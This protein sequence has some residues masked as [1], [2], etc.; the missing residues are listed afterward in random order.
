[1]LLLL[2]SMTTSPRLRRCLLAKFAP[3]CLRGN[4][5]SGRHLPDD[6]TALNVSKS[7]TDETCLPCQKCVIHRAQSA[8]HVARFVC[9]ALMPTNNGQMPL[10]WIFHARR[11][12]YRG[13][14]IC[15]WQR[16]AVLPLL[17]GWAHCRPLLAHVPVNI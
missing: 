7:P 14:Q 4:T 11:C 17:D 15:L 5:S 12:F 16:L 3:A 2:Q 6:T 10:W 13:R 1:M 9:R 8:P